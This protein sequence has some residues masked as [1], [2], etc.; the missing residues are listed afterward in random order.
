[1]FVIDLKVNFR[2]VDMVGRLGALNSAPEAYAA[3]ACPVSEQPI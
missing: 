1:M 2:R 3:G